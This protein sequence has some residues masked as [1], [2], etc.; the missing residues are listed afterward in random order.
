MYSPCF[1]NV[2]EFLAS[3]LPIFSSRTNHRRIAEGPEGKIH[4]LIL[5]HLP[6]PPARTKNSAELISFA[7]ENKTELLGE[8]TH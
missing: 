3:D 6:S 4:A 8:W 2:S 1:Y 7:V 5:N